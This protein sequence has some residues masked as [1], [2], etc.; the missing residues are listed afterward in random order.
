MLNYF[1]VQFYKYWPYIKQALKIFSL[2][3]LNFLTTKELV[4]FMMISPLVWL[5]NILFFSNFNERDNSAEKFFIFSLI[6]FYLSV[7]IYLRQSI[8]NYSQIEYF[9][10]I[11]PTDVFN[12]TYHIFIDS[13]SIYLIMLTTLLIPICT[14]INFTDDRLASLCALLFILE[15]CLIQAFTVLDI[16]LFFLFFESALIPLFL[17]I[18]MWGSRQRRVK[19]AFG[20]FLYTLAGSISLLLAIIY[21]Y[22]TLGTTNYEEIIHA[23]FSLFTENILFLAFFLSFAVKMPLFPFHIWLPEAHG[24]ASTAGSIL[25]AGILLKL[26][27]YGFIRF[28]IPFFPHSVN[29]FRPLVYTICV[30]GI[31]FSSFATLRQIDI[32]RVVAYSSV[33]HMSLA[34]LAIF[35]GNLQGIAGGVFLLI[36]HGIISSALFLLVGILYTRYSTRL[37][38]YIGGVAPFMPIFSVIFLIF[39]LSNMGFPGT[40]GFM[41]EFLPTIGIFQSN[42]LVAIFTTPGMLLSAAYSMWFFSRICFGESNPSIRNWVTRINDLTQKELFLLS[43][44]FFLNIYLGLAPNA[45]LENITNDI[46]KLLVQIFK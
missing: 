11:I 8:T 15:F 14:L 36:S 16:F 1:K 29:F 10:T 45:I 23:R 34:T 24:E 22:N 7:L 4:M 41:G 2:I 5:F 6:T 35:S 46:I 27:G 13:I 39:N 32:K 30:L 26:G 33:A 38:Y 28:V 42:M 37:I 18:G 43:I 21:L 12:F 17:L 19:A 20:L 31:I 9:V 44:F 3:S 40:A 25:L